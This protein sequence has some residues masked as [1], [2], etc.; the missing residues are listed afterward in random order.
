[1][2]NNPTGTDLI[3][4]SPQD[5]TVFSSAASSVKGAKESDYSEDEL[6][7]EEERKTLRLIADK[8]PLAA[9][10]IAVVEFG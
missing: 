8:I 2:A 5:R 9:I 10:L 6:P 7:T 4:G 1:M 3:G